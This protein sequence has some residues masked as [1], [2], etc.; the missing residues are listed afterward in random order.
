M[1]K[2][3][4]LT[5]VISIDGTILKKWEDMAKEAILHFEKLSSQVQ[6]E[7]LASLQE[8]LD[9]QIMAI[10]VTKREEMEKPLILSEIHTTTKAMSKGKVPNLDGISLEFFIHY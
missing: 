4:K 5:I 7:D 3:T 8:V 2:A 10:N 1:F 6:R 9:S